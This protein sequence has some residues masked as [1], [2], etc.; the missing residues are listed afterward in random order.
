MPDHGPRLQCPAGHSFD[1][2]KQGYYNFL[3]GK[4]T[5][6]TADSAAMAASRAA[7]LDS[8]H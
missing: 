1:A 2:A 3:T 4:G 8:G 7:C 5:A 6:F